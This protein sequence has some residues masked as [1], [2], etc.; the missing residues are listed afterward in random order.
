[1]SKTESRTTLAHSQSGCPYKHI[2]GIPGQGF[3]SARIFGFALYDILATIGLAVF[4][5]YFF[6]V[7]FLTAL[8]GWFVFG[9]VLH[10]AFGTQTA[11]LTA[12][13][14]VACDK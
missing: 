7:G 6:N 14:I 13:G 12:L 8:I 3:H 4:T 2:L 11:V 5:W 9:E 1:M 10:W